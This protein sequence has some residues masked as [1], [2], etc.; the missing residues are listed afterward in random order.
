MTGNS[1]P[2]G[3]SSDF[4]PWRHGA[5][6]EELPSD[7]GNERREK[8]P[9]PPRFVLQSRRTTN[10]ASP[11]HAVT[12]LGGGPEGPSVPELSVVMPCLNEADTLST[13]ILKA[14]RAMREAGIEGEIIVADNG[15]TDTSREIAIASG[16]RLV[17]VV[18]RGYGS[19][20]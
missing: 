9:S 10:S 14:R 12:I 11:M 20:L 1:L 8:A 15:S 18:E 19:A 4:E 13:C 7:P 2:R 16:A 3:G 5:P 17:D 6:D